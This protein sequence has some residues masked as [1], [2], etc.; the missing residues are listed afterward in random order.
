MS[1][2]N[3]HGLTVLSEY[4]IALVA[5]LLIIISY[6]SNVEILMVLKCVAQ[7]DSSLSVIPKVGTTNS[8]IVSGEMVHK[9][10]TDN[11]FQKNSGTVIYENN[12]DTNISKNNG[13]YL[14][15]ISSKNINSSQETNS[16]DQLEQIYLTSTN[17]LGFSTKIN[18]YIELLKQRLNNYYSN[19]IAIIIVIMLVLIDSSISKYLRNRANRIIPPYYFMLAKYGVVLSIVINICFLFIIAQWNIEFFIGLGLLF[20]SCSIWFYCYTTTLVGSK[21]IT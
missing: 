19:V 9:L 20:L 12:T 14:Y 18:I 13:N 3:S 8:Y 6:L 4:A 2:E 15:V 1:N 11:L 5:I 21:S 10:F 7:N 16:N 17:S